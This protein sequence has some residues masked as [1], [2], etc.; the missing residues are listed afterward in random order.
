MVSGFEF[1]RGPWQDVEWLVNQTKT[2][3]E[4]FVTPKGLGTAAKVTAAKIIESRN[5]KKSEMLWTGDLLQLIEEMEIIYVPKQVDP[6]PCILFPLRD[7]HGNMNSGR[8]KPFYELLLKYGPVKY[9][10]LGNSEV[11]SG[12]TWFGNSDE[13]LRHIAKYRSVG[14]VEGYFDNLACRLMKP[15]APILS[16]GLKTINEMHVHYLQMLGV[17]T[18]N[19]MFDDDPAKEGFMLGAGAQAM[20]SI[21]KHWDGKCGIEFHIHKLP[22]NDPSLCLESYEPAMRLRHLLQGMFRA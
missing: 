20:E 1:S 7:Y 16:T 21:Q 13:T 17:K 3:Y 19:L 12:P 14:L 4:R 6:G 18:V 11:I 8:I 2:Y 15:D 22:A 10:Y 9:G 5:W